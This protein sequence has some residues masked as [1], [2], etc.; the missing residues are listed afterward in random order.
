MT[1][2]E[3]RQW[4]EKAKRH[5]LAPWDHHRGVLSID[6]NG[7]SV[8]ARASV[9]ET[10]EVL[11]RSAVR[12][13]K[14]VLDRPVSPGDQNLIVF[15]LRGHAWTVIVDDPVD[16]QGLSRCLQTEV[17]DY[18]VSDTCGS[19]GYALFDRGEH[20]ESFFGSDDGEN[21]FESEVR[22]LSK[23]ER[24]D[25]WDVVHRFF[26]AH[27]ACDPGLAYEYFFRDSGEQTSAPR[28]ILPN[29][30]PP[31]NRPV[32]RNPGIVIA[33]DGEDVMSKPE[34]ERIDFVVTRENPGKAGR[35]LLR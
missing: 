10:A 28:L 8:H 13:E 14:D 20:V 23:K 11:S 21:Q 35:I 7:H 9:E 18:S 16:A 33:I 3:R 25:I 32:L 26:V 17:I 12:W 19:T 24:K 27:D 34:F 2:E 30:P 5:Y 4:V 1:D 6:R 29:A 15:R 31:N 22:S